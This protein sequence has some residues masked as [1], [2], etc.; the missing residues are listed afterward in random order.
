[1]RCGRITRGCCSSSSTTSS[2]ASPGT[3]ASS[4][5]GPATACSRRCS[6]PGGTTCSTWGSTSARARSPIPPVR[7][8]RPRSRRTGT[9]WSSP[10]RRDPRSPLAEKA[11]FDAAICCEVLEH[12]DDPG[13]LLDGAPRPRYAGR[14]ARSSRPSRTWRPKTTSSSST[15]PT[16]FVRSSAATSSRSTRISRSSWPGRRISCRNR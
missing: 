15:M 14:A 7:S 8:R 1:M 9:S 4:R 11:P 10:T 13:S 5:S 6:S 12:V 3:V 2:G 16:T